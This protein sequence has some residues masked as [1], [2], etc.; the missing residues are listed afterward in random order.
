ML[1][2]LGTCNEEERAQLNKFFRF[3]QACIGDEMSLELCPGQ[4]SIDT[5]CH[6]TAVASITCQ[7]IGKE[8]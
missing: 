7:A 6:C 5:R 4:A 8:Q 2:V 1:G 3:T